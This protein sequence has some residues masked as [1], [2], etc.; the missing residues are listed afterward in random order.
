MWTEGETMPHSLLLV[1]D[2]EQVLAFMQPFLVAEGFKVHTARTGM[3]ALQVAKAQKPDLVVLDWMMPG[4]SG[5][6]V[7][8]EL[9]K[10]GSF[11][12]VMVTARSEETEKIVAL[13]LGADDY[14]TKPFSLR[15]LAARIRAVLRRLD[16]G[17]AHDPAPLS[18]K[19]LEISETKCRVTK[20]GVEIPLTPKE[21]R[22]VLTLAS[23]PGVVYSRLQL[24]RSALNDEYNNDERTIDAHISHIRKKLED[25]PASPVYI[26]TVFGF[27][28]RFGD[29]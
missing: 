29:E 1:D 3:A 10:I 20:R 6:D 9:R 4:M 19:E 12:I 11:G 25:D 17:N 21:F 18:W 28:Y 24:L 22:I 13:E 5:L 2:E 26:Q 16:P 7:C 8:R 15:E 27:G 23:R 14:L